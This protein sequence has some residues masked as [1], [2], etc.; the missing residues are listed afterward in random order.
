MDHR[1]QVIAAVRQIA[2]QASRIRLPIPFQP[3]KGP[4]WSQM[5]EPDRSSLCARLPVLDEM[6]DR[7]DLRYFGH[8]HTS[9]TS[10]RGCAQRPSLGRRIY[11][12]EILSEGIF[13]SE[14]E[15]CPRVPYARP[16]LTTEN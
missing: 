7:N 5:P 10:L 11:G 9:L 16:L 3:K 14:A 8:L 6:H 13:L 15:I 2:V 12:R 4:I 1:N